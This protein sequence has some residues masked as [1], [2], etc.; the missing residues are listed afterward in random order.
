MAKILIVDD[1]ANI[2]TLYETEFEDEGYEVSTAESAQEALDIISKENF[3]LIILDIRMPGV[4]GI[5]ALEKIMV[6][7][8]NLPVLINSAYP[9]YKDNFLTWLAEDYI[10]KS[11]DLGYLK[12]KVAETLEK[13]GKA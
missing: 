1:E 7:N 2:R 8:R 3:D 6:K 11:S 4:D 9:A 12:K 5:S 10:I 13:R